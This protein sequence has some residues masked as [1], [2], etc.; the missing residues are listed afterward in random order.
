MKVESV[1][2]LSVTIE[3]YKFEDSTAAPVATL[4]SLDQR[5]MHK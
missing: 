2:N 3:K 1:V 5:Y 4:Q